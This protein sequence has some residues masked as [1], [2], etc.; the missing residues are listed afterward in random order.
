MASNSAHTG[1]PP[2]AIAVLNQKG[3]TGKTTTSVNLAAGLADAGLS[4]LLVDAD[5]QGAV[6]TS[7]G[8]H[9]EFNL[10]HL[11][12]GQAAMADC[13]VPIRSELDVLTSDARLQQVELRLSMNADD[14]RTLGHQ[15]T[16]ARGYEYVIVDCPPVVN[17]LVETILT[18]AGEV[19]IPVSC[20]YL[21]MVPVKQVLTILERLNR[22]QGSNVR[23]TGIL[24]TFF[25]GRNRI[26]HDV[27]ETLR[28]YFGPAV[29]PPVRVNT[30]LREAP[31]WRK[32]IFEYAPTSHGAEDYRE[33]VRRIIGG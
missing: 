3:G 30:R 18:H 28:K 13:V 32:T 24:P 22:E 29:L 25:D 5:P 27:L 21:S 16:H 31:S 8:V 9:G 14:R 26:S 1:R 20:D 6:G 15:L 23:V 7:L 10:F 17:V 2:R 12:A 33:V 11:L 19:L 4:T